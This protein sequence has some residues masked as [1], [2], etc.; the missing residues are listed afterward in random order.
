MKKK[1]LGIIMAAVMA[2]T[3]AAALVGCSPRDEVLKIYNWGD[4]IDESL[5][6]EFEDWYKVETGKNITVQYDTFETTEDVITRIEVLK[7]DYDLVCPSDYIAERMIKGG[8]VQ[9]VDKDIFDVTDDFLYDGLAEMVKPFDPNNEYYVPYVWGTFGI[10]Y[11]TNY[12]DAGSEDMASWEAM[13]SAKYKKHILMK[14]SVRD[15]Y[16]V[17]QIYA[18]REKLSQLSDG[19]TDYNDEYRKELI[20]YF[21]GTSE[22]LIKTAQDA[23][24]TQKSLLYK[25]EVDDGKNDMLAGTTE[26]HLGLF[27]SCD[28]CLIMQEDGGDHFYYEVPKEGSN[29]WVDGWLI[30]KYAGNVTAANYFLKFINLYD[31]D[32]DYAMT[33]FDYMG[34]SMAS[35]AVMEDAKAALI[36]DED[37][38]FEDKEEWFKDMYIDMLFP[39]EEV[40]ARCG[41]MRDFGKKWGTELDSMWIDVKT[42]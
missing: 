37:G 8:L 27:W 10:M 18:N 6:G 24:V 5:I 38:F 28:T 19:F 12:I 36:E 2:T 42:L 33:N 7:S 31:D 40:L 4:Y 39:S 13:W 35:K 23:L 22:N 16:S 20:S 32:H 17:A 25:Y 34:A 29:V 26:A 3:S 11:D 14:D 21:T 1:I 30:P 9:K 15:A 41:V